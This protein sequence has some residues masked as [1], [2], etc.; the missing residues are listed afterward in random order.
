[1]ESVVKALYSGAFAIWNALIEIAMT[2]FTTSPKVAGGGG[3]YATVHT[4]FNAISDATIPI[5]TVFFIIALYKTVVSAPPEQQA[6][7]FLMDALKYCMILFVAANLWNIMGYIMDFSDG[8]TARI[9]ATSGY[10]LT[11]SGD[12][13]NIIEDCLELPEFELTGE[14]FEELW[15]VVGCSLI[16]MLA[17]VV[18]LLVM[19][20]SCIS[21]VSCAFQRIL[22]PLI[23]LPFAGI[24][25]AMGAGGADISRS[26]FNYMKTFFGF[27]IS[28]AVMIIAV[29]TGVSLC[30]DLVNFNLAGTSDIYKCIMIT[31]QSAITPIVI[32]GLVKG[33]DSMISRMF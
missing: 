10:T 18:L 33:S 6:Q 30:T 13:E 1:M 31:V 3:P 24:A 17:G 16:F 5:A 8:I 9:S 20:A 4:I 27:C 32:S 25:V 12:L 19:V 22:K 28:G 29:K 2:L 23:I 15:S 11:M 14:W 21:I 7:R 26:M